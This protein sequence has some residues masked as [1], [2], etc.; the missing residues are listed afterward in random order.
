[1]EQD[2]PKINEASSFGILFGAG[3]GVPHL[4]IQLV[5]L[6]LLIIGGDVLLG[7]EKTDIT[8]TAWVSLI[9][10][11]LS[12]IV[13][14][15]S[16][17][18]GQEAGRLSRDLS[19]PASSISY[20]STSLISVLSSTI[21][22]AISTLLLIILLYVDS[23]A[24]SL[25]SW[26]I[27]SLLLLL[28]LPLIQCLLYQ[29]FIREGG[30]Q[31][32]AWGLLAASIPVRFLDMDRRRARN[33]LFIS[34]TVWFLTHLLSW[35][36]FSAL[37]QSEDT[38]DVVFRVWLP[39]IVPILLLPPLTSGLHWS[40]SLAPL[41][42]SK[43]AHP[44]MEDRNKRLQTFPPDW[45]TLSGSTVTVDS[46]ADAGFFYS[47]R[48]LSSG[49]ATCFSCGRQVTDWTWKSAAQAHSQAADHC[50]YYSTEKKEEQ[51]YSM[52]GTGVSCFAEFFFIAVT[53]LFRIVSY[54]LLLWVFMDQ[55]LSISSQLS[56]LYL[57][58]LLYLIIFIL[59]NAWCHF[60]F[61]P[62]SGSRPLWALISTLV[63]RPSSPMSL[64]SAASY[65][66][67]NVLFNSIFHCF[68]WAAMSSICP[69]CLATL[70]MPAFVTAWPIVLTLGG[71]AFLSS[72]PYYFFTL[73]PLR[74]TRISPQ[75]RNSFVVST[76]L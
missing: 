41:Y 33:F 68:L 44:D 27:L 20:L 49:E 65:L 22:S 70:S 11:L 52:E 60:S 62:P 24:F 71:L 21:V 8:S 64:S 3:Q 43:H 42:N 25:P 6:G 1:V 69:S 47:C 61:N 7:L 54:C 57:I 5:V 31:R 50:P 34:Q 51:K 23:Q 38:S 46:L 63:P 39:V 4:G 17:L 59:F 26:L 13:L 55:W 56:P 19:T 74:P 36:V 30:E 16:F 18:S 29:K 73:K 10:I 2:S 9:S 76:A 53:L 35:L 45:R 15:V 66:L 48:R 67:I 75:P 40:I 72:I 32:F 28:L 14:A 58:P 12:C 37:G